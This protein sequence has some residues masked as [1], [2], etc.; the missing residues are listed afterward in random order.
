MTVDEIGRRYQISSEKL[1]FYLQN[2]LF[3]AE[4]LEREDR[5]EEWQHRF[6]LIH[7]L[8]E[9]GMDL[10]EIK[11]YLDL[12]SHEGTASD[13]QNRDKQKRLLAGQRCRLLDDVHENQKRLDCLDYLIYKAK[14][15]RNGGS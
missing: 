13:E 5:Q 6:C 8:E 15:Q 10:L 9:S 11:R 4:E 2:G 12:R 14:K 7:T 1:R 3:T